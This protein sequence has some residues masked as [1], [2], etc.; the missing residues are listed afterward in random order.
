MVGVIRECLLFVIG[1]PLGPCQSA[2][3]LLKVR[4][5]ASKQVF[6]RSCSDG[7]FKRTHGW[8]VVASEWFGVCIAIPRFLVL[9]L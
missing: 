3:E 6:S 7:A 4:H 9:F 8:V 2:K 1:R 5:F